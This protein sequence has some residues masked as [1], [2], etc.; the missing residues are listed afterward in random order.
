MTVLSGW[1]WPFLGWFLV[2]GW[3][4]WLLRQRLATTRTHPSSPSQAC[5]PEGYSGY[6]LP[7]ERRETATGRSLRALVIE[8]AK[9]IAE[10]FC[11]ILRGHNYY[12]EAVPTLAQ[13]IEK[14][15]AVNPDV[16]VLD[17]MLPDADDLEALAEILRAT[18]TP[19]VVVTAL[20]ADELIVEGARVLGAHAVI[21]KGEGFSPERLLESCGGAIAAR[22][23]QQ[24]W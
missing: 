16:V 8:D 19:V 18:D 13:G 17:L 23:E 22:A 24:R 9:A 14:I 21:P 5:A 4:V 11:M 15:D 3:A 1:L 2:S 20:A 7:H 12:A 10:M 6:S